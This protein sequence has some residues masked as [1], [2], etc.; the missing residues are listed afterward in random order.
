VT[1]IT[2]D[3]AIVTAEERCLAACALADAGFLEK[4][5]LKDLERIANYILYGKTAKGNS[6]PEAKEISTKHSTWKKKDPQS[7]DALMENIMFDETSLKPFNNRTPY[8]NPKPK[9]SRDTDRDIPGMVDL[10]NDID[11]AEEYA[12]TLTDNVKKYY[13]RHLL[14]DMRKEQYL[15]DLFRPT[16]HFTSILD[17]G[18]QE[19]DWTCDSGYAV[20]PLSLQW[21]TDAAGRSLLTYCGP[22]EWTWHTVAEHT[23]D[24][25]NPVHIYHILDLYSALCHQQYDNP[26]SSTAFLLRAVECLVSRTNLSPARYHILVRKVDHAPNETI[27]QELLTIYGLD[28]AI[29]YI[30]TIWTKEICGAIAQT[31]QI[32]LDEAAARNSPKKWKTCTKCHE[33]KLRD[34]RFFAKKR[35]THDQ[36]S[37]V[38]RECQKKV[39]NK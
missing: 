17:G 37:P 1:R 25:T 8:T 36:L 22:A 16:I 7:L 26:T 27:A 20:E 4:A 32:D 35:N 3:Y 14:I 23:I 2:L 29:N 24:L 19:I 28:Y 31:G 6:L 34:A 21:R 11:T 15:K 9:I 10:W 18:I 33:R 13:M 5:P 39:K 12:K 38:C 30:S